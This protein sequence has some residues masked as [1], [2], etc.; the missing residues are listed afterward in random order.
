[1]THPTLTNPT[2]QLAADPSH[3][4]D[5][6]W[7]T[8]RLRTHQTVFWA[9]IHAMV[10]QDTCHS[11][12]SLLQE[13]HGHTSHQHAAESTDTI[14]RSTTALDLDTTILTLRGNLDDLE[15]T[16]TTGQASIQLALHREEPVLHTGGSGIFPFLGATS[17]QYALPGLTTTGTITTAHTTHQVNGRTWLDRQ[18][19]LE[20][21]HT[22]Q[23][24]KPPRF[25]WLGLDLGAGRYLSVWD[26]DGDG[27]SWLTALHAD[28]TH[29]ITHAQRTDHPD[30]GWKLTVPA[31]HA[32]LRIT[33]QP[34]PD[35]H[36][37]LYAAVCR[38]TGTLAD[39]NINAH[40]Y[41][42]ILG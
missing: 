40:G 30:G 19:K 1:M 17:G 9:K 2:E 3:P 41:A 5:S 14:T 26:T 10:I 36:P 27:T 31:L 12:V 24:T 21:P 7:F 22:P 23:N 13:P 34:L 4:V 25:T 32:T 16:G 39:E 15:I 8:A 28:G 18:W 35:S 38:V 29:T 42:D 33:H 11:T 20:G 6:W 37:G